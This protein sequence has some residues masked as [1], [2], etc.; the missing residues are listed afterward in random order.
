MRFLAY[1]DFAGNYYQAKSTF[2][3]LAPEIRDVRCSGCSDCAIQ[4]P[5]GVLVQNRLSRAQE[6]LA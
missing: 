2:Q 5:N 1:T 3:D 6:L 4:C